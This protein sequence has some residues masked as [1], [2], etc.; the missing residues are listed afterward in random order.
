MHHM[1][2]GHCSTAASVSTEVLAHVQTAVL[3]VHIKSPA[4]TG[5]RRGSCSSSRS[6]QP[7]CSAPQLL[8]GK[9]WPGASGRRA[10]FK[11]IAPE[12]ISGDERRADDG[13]FVLNFPPLYFFRKCPPKQG[14]G[15]LPTVTQKQ[16][17]ARFHLSLS[18][19]APL[20]PP[21]PPRSPT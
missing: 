1:P 3:L 12:P 4:H 8:H 10:R 16:K 7:T 5:S 21:T 11:S 18:F 15:S 20:S 17:N 2:A 13:C 19:R 14:N 9:E 6:C